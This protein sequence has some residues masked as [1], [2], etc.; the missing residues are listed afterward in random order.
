L[1]N[2]A[3]EVL[4]YH[5][6]GSIEPDGEHTWRN[7]EAGQDLVGFRELA[8]KLAALV[9]HL[10]PPACFGI[11]GPWGSGKSTLMA[12]IRDN[13]NRE[14]GDKARS[15][16]FNTWVHDQPNG[17]DVSYALLRH[18][19]RALTPPG[20]AR[21][22]A[23]E[24]VAKKFAL[25]CLLAGDTVARVLTLGAVSPLEQGSTI[26]DL[27]EGWQEAYEQWVD[28]A[29]GVQAAFGRAL[30]RTLKPGERLFVFLDDLDRCLPANV[31]WVLQSLKNVFMTRRV[32][33]V[34]GVDRAAAVDAI[35]GVHNYSRAF[36]GRYL[37]KLVEFS[38]TISYGVKPDAMAGLVSRMMRKLQVAPLPGYAHQLGNATGALPESWTANPRVIKRVASKLAIVFSVVMPTLVDP[39][40]R[41][42]GDGKPAFHDL[43]QLGKDQPPFLSTLLAVM[44][45]KERYPLSFSVFNKRL[46]EALWMLAP[47][48]V[49]E[50][51][52]DFLRQEVFSI[53]DSHRMPADEAR[54]VAAVLFEDLQLDIEHLR[55]LY[56]ALGPWL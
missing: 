49:S 7:I 27:D 23:F 30:Q 51:G 13:L 14:L 36:G 37:D 55:V 16:W 43:P 21:S 5:S 6:S 34:L 3:C 56:R 18:I 25:A 26:A 42:D 24:K 31:V 53:L 32:V 48:Q 2:G 52:T 20:T 35:C 1:F 22:G 39:K 54:V 44:M 17:A 4:Q 50:L 38:H 15:V 19:E 33:F 46:S 45:L 9:S 40:I 11:Y 8:P 10:A 41:N 29:A 12:C 28:A 47:A